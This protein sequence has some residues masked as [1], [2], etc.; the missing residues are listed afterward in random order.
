MAFKQVFKTSLFLCLFGVFC[1]TREFFT[2]LDTLPL[3]VKDCK[4][5]PML[6]TYGHWHTYCDTG[7]SFIIFISE[8]RG[9]HTYCRTFDSGAVTA[10]FNELSLSRNPTIRLRGKR[11]N[12]LH[13]RRGQA[14]HWKTW[15][16]LAENYLTKLFKTALKRKCKFSLNLFIT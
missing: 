9:T 11:S 4:F 1:P 6:G 7:H 2:H 14:H 8:S 10:C 12:Q 5:L 13:H 3:R 15:K 16:W